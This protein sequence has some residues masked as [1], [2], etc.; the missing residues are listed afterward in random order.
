[1]RPEFLDV[2]GLFYCLEISM[3]P[4]MQ[5]APEGM[6]EAPEAEEANEICVT[7]TAQGIDVDG[8]PAGDIG[9]ALKMVMAKI[10]MLQAETGDEGAAMAA[11][12]QSVRPG[13]PR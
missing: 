5:E 10:K 9:A 8:E 12:F 4:M 7:V 1:L 11:G 3:D 13:S 2:L 6:E